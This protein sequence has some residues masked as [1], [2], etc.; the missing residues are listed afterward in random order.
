MLTLAAA[1]PVVMKNY[2]RGGS[3][4]SQER[5]ARRLRALLAPQEVD[6]LKSVI[7]QP[8]YVIARLRMLGQASAAPQPGQRRGLASLSTRCRRAAA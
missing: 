2:L 4:S 8:Q 3:K 6:A 1:F 7:N 5:D